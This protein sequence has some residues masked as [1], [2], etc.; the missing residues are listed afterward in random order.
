MNLTELHL[1]S[2]TIQKIQND[3]FKNLKVEGNEHFYV[4]NEIYIIKYCFQVIYASLDCSYQGE[5]FSFFT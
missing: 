5:D 3:P 1:M 2:N 4:R